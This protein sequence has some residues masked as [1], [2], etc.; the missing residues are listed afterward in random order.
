MIRYA[1]RRVLSLVPVWVGITLVAFALNALTP[2]DPA[3]VILQQRT[4]ES[5]SEEEV[6]ALREE[7]GLNDP[8]PLRFARYVANAATGDLGTSYRTGEAVLPALAGRFLRTLQLAVPALLLG[9]AV[10]IPLGVV[11]AARRNTVVDHGA[12]VGALVGASI[13]SFWLAYLLILLFAVSLH[14]LP[15]AGY[16]NWRHLVL[17]SVTLAF[18]ATAALTRLTRASVLD[19]LGEQYIGTA[20]AVGLPRRRVL[21]RHALKNALIPVVTLAGLRFGALLG[22]AVIV[23]TVFAWPGLGKHVVDAIYD[24]D[25]P[26]VQGFVLFT[27]TVFVLLNLLI[28]LTYV[29]LD[30]R[31]R[32]AGSAG[33]AGV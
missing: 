18:G 25:Y 12:R 10:A 28:D 8:L 4:A 6:Q 7:L 32:L 2:G 5:P 23:E 9:L 19:V 22:G 1:A 21:F 31:V 27:G 29:R 14:L 33:R 3:R 30:P 20:L 16:G 11:S 13:P 17:P 24:R 26:T 15:V